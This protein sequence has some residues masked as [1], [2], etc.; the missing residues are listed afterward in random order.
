MP[1]ELAWRPTLGNGTG[2]PATGLKLYAIAH[3]LLI[4]QSENSAVLPLMS[5]QALQ[6]EMKY[7][8]CYKR[9]WLELN[10]PGKRAT[11]AISQLRLA[12]SPYKKSP[13]A[14]ATGLLTIKRNA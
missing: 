5:S 2:E 14:C 9:K 12:G 11:V 6:N 13:A 4:M 8:I 10:S 1:A 7:I 3:R